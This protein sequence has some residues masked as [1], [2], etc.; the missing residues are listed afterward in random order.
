MAKKHVPKGER[1]TQLFKGQ[2]LRDIQVEEGS[3]DLQHMDL[4]FDTGVLHLSP[5]RLEEISLTLYTTVTEQMTAPEAETFMAGKQVQEVNHE[6]G[7]T[8][9]RFTNGEK[10]IISATPN[11]EFDTVPAYEI[12][13]VVQETL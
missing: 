2:V 11:R 8:I 13:R 10:V 4:I 5:T 9:I 3:D 12:T 7:N 1:L 6:Q